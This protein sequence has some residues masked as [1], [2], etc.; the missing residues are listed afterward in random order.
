MHGPG[1][2]NPSRTVK[3]LS[4]SIRVRGIS[5]PESSFCAMFYGPQSEHARS[6]IEMDRENAFLCTPVLA[7][8]QKRQGLF[9]K[10]GKGHGFN[11]P[12]SVLAPMGR[13]TCGIGPIPID[14]VTIIGECTC[15]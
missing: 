8:L 5:Q 12:P 4:Q 11:G 10:G 6:K 14:V 7:A 1:Q 9:R 2:T 13:Y 3:L 15:P